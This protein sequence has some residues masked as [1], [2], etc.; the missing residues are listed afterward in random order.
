[1]KIPYKH[2]LKY[3]DS[4]L[5]INQLSESL[6]QLG[7]EHEI[8]NEI[9]DFE[10]TP[11]RGD[12]ISLDGMLRDLNLLYDVINNKRIYQK[13]IKP[14][15]FK[16]L[17]DAKESCWNISFLKIDI[18]AVPKKYTNS[19][20]DYFSDLDIKK[21][22]FFTDVSNFISYE[23]GQP[24][25]CYDA[26]KVADYLRLNT[27]NES[28]EFETLLDKKINIEKGDLVFTNEK[29]QVINLAGIVG[30][31]STSCNIG[32]TSVIVE[33]AYFDPEA[34]I[35]KAVKYDINSDAAH[36][37]ERNTDPL[38][39]EYVIRRFLKVV[40]DHCNIINVELFQESYKPK[41][42]TLISFNAVKIN[43]IL[44][45]SIKKN[46]CLSYLKKLGFLVS[47][48]FI[49]VPSYR[50]DIK[51]I[52]DI[53][54][55]IARAVG[56]NNINS[57]KF[58][59]KVTNESKI[60]FNENK[61]K[62]LLLNEGFY[63]VINSPFVSDGSSK[64]VQLDN[65]L[66][67]NKKYLRTNLKDSLLDNLLFNERRQK[68][69]IKLFEVSDLYSNKARI[70]KKVVGMIA[71]G[72]I[73]KNYLDFS[74]KI[75]NKYFENILSKVKSK[76]LKIQE[77]PRQSLNS[78]SK[79]PIFYSEIEIDQH[80]E[81]ESSFDNL[82]INN[83]S[84][85]KYVPI[86]EFPS[87]NRDLSFS[88]KDFSKCKQLEDLILNYR[89]KLLKE[90]FVFDYYKNEK[91]SEIKIGFRFIFQSKESTITDTE[92]IEVMNSVI[93]DA[94]KIDTV[95]IPGL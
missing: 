69:S 11:N 1:M 59:I 36:K 4:D 53:S 25:H 52:N 89:D 44:G 38:C 9:F 48:N 39:H 21:I 88:I 82:N 63:E 64:S 54:E 83:I 10:L 76:E 14:Y 12:C 47:N 91:T 50:N 33:C 61:I 85:I 95:N 68:D 18:D 65:P 49:H 3:I 17:N 92:V 31:E 46:E 29:N 93:S 73:N 71:S 32:T 57:E 87:S 40:E 77:I 15:D 7:H 20:E 16:F 66:D 94:L 58:D 6:F 43:R 28:C 2:F 27:L 23:S 51:T 67:S 35:G 19:L 26:S 5:D 74:K 41:D 86:S 78:K 84:H 45:T 8:H 80:F 56:Y 22:N 30:G 72:R 79:D 37:F 60:N 42:E 55:E 81:V 13:E 75:N 24:T 90:V 34:I 70:G 62:K